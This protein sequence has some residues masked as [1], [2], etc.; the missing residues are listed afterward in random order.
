MPETLLKV[1]ALCKTFGAVQATN[2]LSFSVTKNHIHALIGPN[3]A[4]K[5]TVVNQ[6]SGDILPDSGN[7]LF[8]GTDIT[9]LKAYQRTRLGIGRSFQITQIFE[10]LT[11]AENMSLAICAHSGHNFKFWRHWRWSSPIKRELAPALE[12]VDLLHR[13]DLLALHLSHGE[14]RQLE[15]GMAMIGKPEL[16]ILD[17][18]MAGMG[19]GGTAELSKLI[20]K[21][22]GQCTI[23]LVEHDMD[24]VFSLADRVTV[25]VYGEDLA[26]GTPDEIRKNAQVRVAYLGEEGECS[27]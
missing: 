2:N 22:R 4:G 15:V 26:T 20:G 7:I 3:G 24:V 25:L 5:T 12:Q 16:L 11:V 6:L 19:P 8:N 18:P 27:Q 9:R 23:L 17:E 13:A 21:L 10:N 14:K 1:T